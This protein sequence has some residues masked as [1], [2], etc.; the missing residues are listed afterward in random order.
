[1]V[2]LLTEHPIWSCWAWQ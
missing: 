1:M 2:Y